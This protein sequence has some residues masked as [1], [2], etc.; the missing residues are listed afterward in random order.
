MGLFAAF[1][2]IALLG[3]MAFVRL[4]P[5]DAARWHVG[6]TVQDWASVA[7]NAV[8]ARMDGALLRLTA[9]QGTAQDLLARLQ[10]IALATPRTTLIAGSVEEGRITW[11]TRSL[12]WGFPDYTTAEL[13]PDGVGLNARLRFGGSDLGVNAARLSDWLARLQ[14]ASG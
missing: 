10:T 3:L 2:M 4:A 13:L 12:L 1:L 5:V 14:A 8:Q 9:D 11:Q 6:Q 7:P